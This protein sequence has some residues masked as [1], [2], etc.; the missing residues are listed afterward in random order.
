[1]DIVFF[2]QYN[3]FYHVYC[4]NALFSFHIVCSDWPFTV[5]KVVQPVCN[6]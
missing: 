6:E 5:E 4:I 3:H 1:M 2:F